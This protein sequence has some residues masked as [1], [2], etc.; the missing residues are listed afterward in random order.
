MNF[1]PPEQ[2]DPRDDDQRMQ[3]AEGMNMDYPELPEPKYGTGRY[4]GTAVGR[5]A[6]TEDQMRAYVD[7]DRA[8]RAAPVVQVGEPTQNEKLLMGQVKAFQDLILIQQRR[9][10]RVAALDQ[11]TAQQTPP[12]AVEVMAPK[13]VITYGCSMCHGSGVTVAGKLCTCRPNAA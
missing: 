6:Y 4:L 7:A 10:E 8:Q 11:A 9:M 3:D 1:Q 13:P 5:S 12:A 2:D